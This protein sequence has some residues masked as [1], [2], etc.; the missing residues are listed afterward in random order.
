MS[1]WRVSI[2][3]LKGDVVQIMPLQS[4]VSAWPDRGSFES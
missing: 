2:L 3:L 4:Q 1:G